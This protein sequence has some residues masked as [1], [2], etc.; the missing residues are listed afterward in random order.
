MNKENIEKIAEEILKKIP[1]HYKNKDYF[2][3]HGKYYLSDNLDRKGNTYTGFI[4]WKD[5]EESTEEIDVV[6]K[7]TNEAKEIIK[8]VLKDEY[9]KGGTIKH[10][11][12][13]HGL[14]M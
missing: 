14:Y 12:Q 2:E 11:E 8:K 4:T 7:D 13:R 1:P 10:V 3:Y 5:E 9:R 6:A